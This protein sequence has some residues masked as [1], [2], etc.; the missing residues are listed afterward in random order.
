M[1]WDRV[2]Q[3]SDEDEP[4]V[5]EEASTSIDPPQGLESFIQG[6]H[7]PGADQQTH[8]PI[9]HHDASAELQLNVNFD[10]FLQSQ[11]NHR[12]NLNSSQQRREERWIPSTGEG[13]GGSIGACSQQASVLELTHLGTGAMMTEIGLAQQRLF[14]DEASSLAQRLPS[15]ATPYSSEISQPGSFPTMPIY[16][17]QQTNEVTNIESKPIKKVVYPSYEATQLV[18]SIQAHGHEYSTPVASTT[19]DSPLGEYGE[20]ISYPSTIHIT[21]NSRAH[22]PQKDTG[23]SKSLQ[24]QPYSPHDTEP[25]SSVASPGVSRAKSDN[26]RSGLMSPR[27]SEADTHDELSLPAV[28]VEVTTVKKRGPPKKQ[29]MPENDDDDELAMVESGS[30][31]SKPEKRKPGRPSKAATSGETTTNKKEVVGAEPPRA[32]RVTIL[33]VK[34][35]LPPDGK[36]TKKKV[37]RSKTADSVM[38]KTRAA[39][40][41]VI[42]VDPRPIQTD[43]NNTSTK[44]T[45]PEPIKG[46]APQS[47]K[48]PSMEEKA[49]SKQSEEQPAPKKRGRKRKTTSEQPIDAEALKENQAPEPPVPAPEATSDIPVE[50]PT[51]PSTDQTPVLETLN[52][53]TNPLPQTPQPDMKT[54]KTPGAHSP[55]SST[56]KVPY[57]VG[58]SKR[59]RIAPLLKVVRK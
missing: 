10:Q 3:D 58:L 52:E 57:R 14:D 56:G 54:R 12:A 19:V 35:P 23:R 33:K 40:D 15:T 18:P 36:E 6:H 29:S 48:N 47:T 21:Q 20:T 30:I 34:A 25:M 22:P 8:Y 59:A 37:K 46:N 5:E 38:Q 7:D 2:I 45:I 26:A 42:W 27:Y 44:T 9:E 24:S 16:Q 4:L 55:I 39:D 51:V 50:K 13:G 28:T 53:P 17:Y 41:D 43:A 49:Q 11:E 32:N 31:K 1:S